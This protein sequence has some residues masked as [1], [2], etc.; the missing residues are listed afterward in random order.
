MAGAGQKFIHIVD[1]ELSNNAQYKSFDDIPS[2]ALNFGT[3]IQ[4]LPGIYEMGTVN[5]DSLTF[6]GIGNRADVILANLKLGAASANTNV[7]RNITLN[8]ANAA[9]TSGSNSIAILDGATGTV[10]FR[11]VVFNNADFAIDNQGRANFLEVQECH[12]KTDRGI[13]S[14]STASA[15][16]WYSV[17]NASSNVYFTT[18]NNDAARPFRVIAS[19]S[20][21]SN[22]GNSVKTVSALIS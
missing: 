8:G 21:G 5:A 16:I 19:Q 1:A 4:F 7:F 18:L 6:E 11:N 15:N 3:T 22:S 14:N 17:L 13:R 2:H 10:T 20:G 9:A 12:M